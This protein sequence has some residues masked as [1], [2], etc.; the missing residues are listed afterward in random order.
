MN[1]AVALPLMIPR[2]EASRLGFLV[3]MRGASPTRDSFQHKGA[4]RWG[5]WCSGRRMVAS[6]RLHGLC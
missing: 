3:G 5:R 2:L 6:I 1:A 4:S